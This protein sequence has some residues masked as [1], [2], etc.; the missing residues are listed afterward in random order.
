MLDLQVFNFGTVVADLSNDVS[1]P[2]CAVSASIK[3]TNAV[4]VPCTVNLSVKPISKD[5]S[6]QFPLGVQP[7]QLVIPAHEYRFAQLLFHPKHIMSFSGMLE[8]IVENGQG[9]PATHKFTCELQARPK[10]ST[11]L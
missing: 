10:T 1:C 5:A 11:F 9:N 8:A 4:K 2:Q 3:I 7:V 6:M